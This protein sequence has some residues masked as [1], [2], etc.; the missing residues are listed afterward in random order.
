MSLI[1]PTVGDNLALEA[2][3]NKT[4]AQDLV[5]KLFQNDYTPVKGDTAANYTV[6]TFSGYADITLTGASWNA[7]AAA[8]IANSIERVFTHNGGATP[9]TIY[10]YFVVQVTS[11]TVLYAERDSGGAFTLTNNGDNVK[12]TPQITAN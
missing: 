6:A 1:F 7:A 9:N 8:A 10:G 11:G 4:A 12:L 2:I 3:V 5:L